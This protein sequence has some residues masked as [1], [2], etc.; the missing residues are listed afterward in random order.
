M[1]ST[2]SQTCVRTIRG[3]RYTDRTI[4]RTTVQEFLAQHRAV[5]MLLRVMHG[6]A[7]GQHAYSGGVVDMERMEG[8]YV[9]DRR[10]I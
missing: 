1:L 3:I 8:I 7:S 6:Y 9:S 2:R 10:G 4:N 5:G